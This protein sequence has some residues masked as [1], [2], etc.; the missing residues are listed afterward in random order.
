MVRRRVQSVLLG[1]SLVFGAF[2]CSE[3]PAEALEN[4]GGSCDG[5][6]GQGFALG[7]VARNWALTDHT[8]E[9]VELF[10]FCGKVI[11]FEEGSQW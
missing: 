6:E 11:F 2:G 9:R 10:D 3:D 1:L 4:P 7:Q 5:A 8:G